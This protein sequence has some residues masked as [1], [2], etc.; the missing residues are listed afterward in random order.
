MIDKLI[1]TLLLERKNKYDNGLYHKLQIDFAFNSNRMEGN[2]LTHDQTRY[3]FETKTLISLDSNFTSVK[4][5]DI[6]ETANH[7]KCFDF[8]LDNYKKPLTDDFIKK[9][10][11]TLK[12]G[13]LE[14][15]D[16]VVIGDYKSFSNVVGNRE[17]ASP[18]EVPKLMDKLLEMYSGKMSLYD[19]VSF[20]ATF[21]GIHPFYDGN[22]RV[23]R[24]I[25]FKQCLDNGILPFFVEDKKKYFYNKG[26]DEWCNQDEDERLIT[27]FLDAQDTME[28]I[29]N[30]FKIEYSRS[31]HTYKDALAHRNKS[32]ERILDL[33][34]PKK[35]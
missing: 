9:I 5:D 8:I 28:R 35:Y 4:V 15:G 21:E 33:R 7:F 16:Y 34:L 29:L 20:H 22:G 25:M 10:H 27:F 11:A 18:S 12:S 19:I 14:E 30:Y 32:V 31:E 13:I 26:L 6:I 1:D 17:T 24:L 3:I 23:G 2:M